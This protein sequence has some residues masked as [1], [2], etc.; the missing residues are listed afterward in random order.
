MA[1]NISKA[2]QLRRTKKPPLSSFEALES[3]VSVFMKKY[4]RISHRGGVK[5][6]TYD[7]NS[8]SI[9]VRV[10]PWLFPVQ[11]AVLYSLSYIITTLTN[12]N[13]FMDCLRTFGLSVYIFF[14]LDTFS[15]LHLTHSYQSKNPLMLCQ[16]DHPIHYPLNYVWRWN[17]MNWATK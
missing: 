14:N 5:T 16:K 7:G 3:H 4:V 15:L 17:L 2:L 6:K 8:T 10:V 12:W 11:V 9:S 13:A 1:A